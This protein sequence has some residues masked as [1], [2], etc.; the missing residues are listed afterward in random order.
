MFEVPGKRGR[1][2]GP[3]LRKVVNGMLYVAHTGCQ[4]RCWPKD[5]GPRTRV[6]SQFRR[7][8]RNGTWARALAELHQ[9]ARTQLGRK[10]S[11]PSTVVMGTRLAR[12]ASHGGATFHR[13]G[14][15]Y[16][17]TKGAKRAVAVDITGLPLAARV[18]AASA[19]ENDT[20]RLILEDMAAR[21]QDERLAT[22]TLD[23]GVTA[24]AARS[25]EKLHR[26]PVKIVGQDQGPDRFVPLPFAWPVEVAHVRLLGS[27]RLARSS[28]DTTASASGWLQVTC[29]ATVL[30]ELF[31]G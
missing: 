1:K 20:T 27:R 7:W 6:W 4:W 28:E 19:Q 2:F 29:V 14:G 13:R 9:V 16:G 25:R 31:S 3:D 21:G 22:V 17:R 11:L 5:Y 18:L 26:V 24:R 12:R 8:S 30:Q 10:G 23:R 15:P